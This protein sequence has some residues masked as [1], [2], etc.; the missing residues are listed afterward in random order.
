MVLTS[1]YLTWVAQSIVGQE[2]VYLIRS[3]MVVAASECVIAF[4]VSLEAVFAFLASGLVT[5]GG[6][7]GR[8]FGLFL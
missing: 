2:A 1:T 4:L 8:F 6:R 5:K 3:L 7:M